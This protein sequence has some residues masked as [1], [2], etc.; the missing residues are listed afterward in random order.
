MG[1]PKG[2]KNRF[3]SQELKLK[4]IKE[5]E[6]GSSKRQVGIKYG[7]SHGLISSWIKKFESGGPDALYAKR[8]PGNPMA[9]AHLKK[10]ESEL[11]RLRYEVALKDVEIMKLKKLM[12][13]R[14]KEGFRK[15]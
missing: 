12:E 15:K 6:G 9:G 10:F 13:I 4:I 5:I 11:E 2:G 1:R 3:H 14:G 8:R 7:I